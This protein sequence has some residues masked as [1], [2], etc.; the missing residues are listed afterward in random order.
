MWLFQ[1]V[2]RCEAT[3]DVVRLRCVQREGAR[4]RSHALFPPYQRSGGNVDVLVNNVGIQ[5]PESCVPLHTLSTE[6]WKRVLNVNLDS[7]FFASKAVR[8]QHTAAY[9]KRLCV[10][11][12]LSLSL[13]TSLSR[14]LSLD[15]STSRPLS[16]PLDLSLSRPVC[17]CFCFSFDLVC[18][19]LMFTLTTRGIAAATCNVGAGFEQDAF[20]HRIPQCDCKHCE[21]SRD[22]VTSRGASIRCFQRRH[23]IV[24]TPGE[25]GLPC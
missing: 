22:S 17:F 8:C 23:A 6:L 12:S 3:V 7:T 15:L 1:Q 2:Q 24:D 18:G 19:A 10:C 9:A 16:R 11:V 21:C 20:V 4:M 13:S 14:P 5:P 25:S